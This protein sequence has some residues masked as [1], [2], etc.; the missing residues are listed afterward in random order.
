MLLIIQDEDGKFTT[1]FSQVKVTDD[2]WEK[3]F[4]WNGRAEKA[5]GRGFK[6][7]KNWRPQA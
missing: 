1:D 2:L 7:E 6:E 4:Q 3:Q 5:D